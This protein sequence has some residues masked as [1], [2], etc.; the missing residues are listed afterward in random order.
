MTSEELKKAI[1]L[2]VPG[3]SQNATDI[4]D[5]FLKMAVSRIGRTRGLDINRKWIEFDLIANKKSL[6]LGVD[7]LQNKTWGILE[8]WRTDI[9]MQISI[10]SID[11]FNV[12]ARGGVATGRPEIATLHNGILE[13]Y[14][15]PD[16]AYTVGAFVK[17]DLKKIDEIDERYYDV[18]YGK[19]IE[20]I[21]AAGNPSIA[22]KV[23][24]Q[25][26]KDMKNDALTEWD[27][28]SIPLARNLGSTYRKKRY[29][30][31]NLR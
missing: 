14:P 12:Y 27:G 31:G 20:L 16:S 18:I 23:A 10:L 9:Q 6:K 7:I 11:E 29:D 2:A 13:L 22:V 28:H 5:T 1:A 8:L 21:N 30:S 4:A 19:A 3:E 25:G 17:I 26:E 15:E 24:D